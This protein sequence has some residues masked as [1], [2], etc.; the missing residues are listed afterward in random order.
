MLLLSY[1]CRSIIF[2]GNAKVVYLLWFVL[3]HVSTTVL[4]NRHHTV[5]A[6]HKIVN[7]PCT[8]AK[9]HVCKFH[10]PP[11][12]HHQQVAINVKIS[13]C[14]VHLYIIY[15]WQCIKCKKKPKN[16]F[17][18]CS[19]KA[20]SNQFAVRFCGEHTSHFPQLITKKKIIFDQIYFFIDS[21]NWL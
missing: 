1:L 11:R 6:I 10:S 4:T 7:N 20:E 9:T 15:H 5:S 12:Q 3:C 19:R 13:R 14:A 17:L 21:I 18:F 2:G 8:R 16:F